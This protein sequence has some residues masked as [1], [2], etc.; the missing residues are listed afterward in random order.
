MLFKVGLQELEEAFAE[1]KSKR[2]VLNWYKWNLGLT[3][4]RAG[5]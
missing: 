4:T 2:I 1:D 3:S 5:S